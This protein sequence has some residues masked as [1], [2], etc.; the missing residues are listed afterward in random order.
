[1]I[2]AKRRETKYTRAVMTVLRRLGHATNA[3]V[4]TIVRAEFPNVSDTTV[5][6]ITSRFYEDGQLELAPAAGD[7]AV[8]YDANTMFHDHFMCESCGTIKDVVLPAALR[9]EM[10][11]MLDGCCLNGSLTLVGDCNKCKER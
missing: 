2:T 9:D 3:E 7:G 4:A 10:Q 11:D 5:H 6:R 1:M 8:R